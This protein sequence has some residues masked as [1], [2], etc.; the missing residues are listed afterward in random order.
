VAK[1]DIPVDSDLSDH[2]LLI[3]ID[4]RT[5]NMDVCLT[6]HLHHHWRVTV[7]V[8]TIALGAVVAA[9]LQAF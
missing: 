1:H 5:Q 6:N 7:L 8:L 2:D 9:V 4:E 3:R